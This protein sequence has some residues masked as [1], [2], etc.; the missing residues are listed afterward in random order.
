RAVD[1]GAAVER[2]AALPEA[3]DLGV[4]ALVRGQ[5]RVP[6]R[7]AHEDGEQR[8]RDAGDRWGPPR[9][10]LDKRAAALAMGVLV[11]VLA[12]TSGLFGLTLSPDRYAVLLLAP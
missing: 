8:S 11:L 9:A 1:P 12:A 7:D 4:P 3:D 5:R 6:E 2:G 10:D